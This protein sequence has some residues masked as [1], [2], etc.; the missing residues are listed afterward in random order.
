MDPND[1]DLLDPLD[2][3]TETLVGPREQERAVREA[4]ELTTQLPLRHGKVREIE[5]RPSKRRD[6]R[7]SKYDSRRPEEEQTERVERRE[8]ID[9]LEATESSV[10]DLFLQFRNDQGQDTSARQE[11]IDQNSFTEMNS[12]QSKRYYDGVSMNASTWFKL[13]DIQANKKQTDAERIDLL[14][15]NVSG[16]AYIYLAEIYYP[17]L[18]YAGAKQKLIDR[19]DAVTID[20]LILAQQRRLQRNETVNTYFE[21]KMRLFDRVKTLTAEQ[22]CASLTNGMPRD[23]QESLCGHNHCDPNEWRKHALRLENL[24]QITFRSQRPVANAATNNRSGQLK[25]NAKPTIPCKFC[26]RLNIPDSDAMHWHKECPNNPYAKTS[27][28]RNGQRSTETRE[29][30]QS[31]QSISS[32][33]ET[34][35]SNFIRINQNRQSN[36]TQ[37]GLPSDGFIFIKTLV[38]G[39]EVYGLLDSGSN[40]HIISFD[41]C[42]RFRLKINFKR[43]SIGQVKDVLP[44]IGE[45]TFPLTINDITKYVT[46]EVVDNPHHDFLIGNIIGE[47]FWLDVNLTQR[48]VSLNVTRTLDPKHCFNSNV[49][50]IL[51]REQIGINSSTEQDQL[52]ELLN[53]FDF[54]FAKDDSDVGRIKNVKHQINLTNETPIY[55]RPYRLPQA[56]ND[57]MDRQVEELLRKKIIRPS[58]SPWNFPAKL[59]PKKDGSKR[60]CINYIPLNQRT[61]DDRFPMPRIDDVIDRLRNMRFKSV[62]DLAWGYW[63]I[64]MDPKDIPK[65]AF[66]T[67]RGHYEWFVMPFGLKNAPIDF[68]RAI[69]NALGDLIYNGCINYI[70][71]IIVYTETFE[72]HLKLLQKVFESLEKAGLKVRREKCNFLQKEVEYLGF[73]IGYNTVKPSRRNL[74]AIELFPKPENITDINSF[75]G[76]AGHYR[77]FIDNFTKIARPLSDLRRKDKTFEWG[78]EQQES[79]D[80]L[81]KLLCSAPVLAIYDPNTLC[82]VYTDACKYGIAGVLTQNGHPVSYFSR[83]LRKEEEDYS[84]TE[85]EFLA[86]IESIEYFHVYLHQKPFNVYSDHEPLRGVIRTPRKEGRLN[87]WAER[88]Y[89]Y[90]TCTIVYKEGRF[91]VVADC[92]SRHPITMFLTKEEIKSHQSTDNRVTTIQNLVKR[93]EIFQIRRNGIYKTFIPQTLVHKLLQQTHDDMGHP[94]IRKMEKLITRKY[95]WKTMALDIRN[96]VR[97]CHECQIVKPAKHLTYG[98]LQPIPTPDKPREMISMDTIIMGKVANQTAHKYIQVIV[99]HHSRYTWAFPSR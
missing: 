47:Q 43:G 65:T 62:L 50:S 58:N 88:L 71:D 30:V 77:R 42:K 49:P 60:L 61:I 12:E 11:H 1:S 93:D 90:P 19:F 39:N 21:E 80:T 84:A 53:K 32:S 98:H 38:N 76:M 41:L 91:N 7:R 28:Q 35:Q 64:S 46:A 55:R 59:A 68:Q 79:F 66:S 8:Q 48:T 20:P 37:T 45:V 85:Q 56:D 44:S 78:Q 2:S 94:G 81:K 82:D 54:I 17:T 5:P 67:H 74:N 87:R 13:F 31:V 72:E 63:Q 69:Q 27:N 29:N 22:K 26:K 70:D 75:L 52:N 36:T 95:W 34:K 18:T 25:S 96:Y 24:R 40:C 57:E 10:E 89:Q 99:D 73:V 33:S 51:K 6:S 97:T 16:Q 14:S 83:R 92:L 23:Y 86:I 9:N 3:S 15:L 4:I